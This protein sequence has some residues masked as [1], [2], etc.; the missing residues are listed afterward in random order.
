[1]FSVVENV[2]YF[3]LNYKTNT[4]FFNCEVKIYFNLVQ[5]FYILKEDLGHWFFFFLEFDAK[6]N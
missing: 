6:N 4:S 3:Y 5:T 1:M 2:H